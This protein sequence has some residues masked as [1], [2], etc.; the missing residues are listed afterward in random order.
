MTNLLPA[1]LTIT[2]LTNPFCSGSSVTFTATPV[3]GGSAPF[4]QWKVN[5][6]SL[7]T[8][9]PGF[10]Y[11]PA[12]GDVVSCE[13]TSNAS[14]ISGANPVTSNL[15]TMVGG[16]TLAAGV[17]ITVSSN[18]VC[19]GVAVAFTATPANGGTS[20]AYQWKANGI[21]KGTNSRIFTYTPSNGEIINCQM[22]SNLV[23]AS[24]NP[25]ISNAITMNVISTVVPSI[26]I[27]PSDRKS[28]RLNSSH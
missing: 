3:N 14:C 10:T 13:L 9:S 11:T 19:Q 28:T 2:T 15:I 4:Y 22:T 6:T 26:S 17:T 21:N 25:A 24:G 20:P 5:G 8:N 23:C 27:L 12:N 16:A 1:S 18:P 7:G